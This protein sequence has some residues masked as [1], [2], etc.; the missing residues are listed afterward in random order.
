MRLSPLLLAL[1]ALPA[2]A[3]G[4]RPGTERPEIERPDATPQAVGAR[5]TLRTIPEACARIEGEFTGRAADPYAFSVV[6]TGA[7][8][9]PRAR[10]VDAEKVRPET[11]AGWIFNDR[12]RVPSAGCPSQAAVVEVWLKPAA[13][14]RP[15][16]DAQ[17]S[18]RVYLQ[19]AQHAGA[20]GLGPIPLFAVSMSV[21]G[22]PCH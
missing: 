16:L 4:P 22:E 11:K 17:G 6:R 13:S 10:L 18:A 1:F 21:E 15:T 8:C 12:I 20:G 9:Q 7:R 14:A 5:H 19:D 2:L 3:A